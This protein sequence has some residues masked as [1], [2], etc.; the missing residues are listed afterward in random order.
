M[1]I[2]QPVKVCIENI[3][4]LNIGDCE[5]SKSTIQLV[6]SFLKEALCTIEAILPCGMISVTPD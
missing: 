6:I 3:C 5:F 4:S 1:L 2:L